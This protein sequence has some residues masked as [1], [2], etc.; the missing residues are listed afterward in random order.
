MTLS[1]SDL[2]LRF[3]QVLR[4]KPLPITDNDP[5]RK[6]AAVL[7]PFVKS[8]GEWH[9]LFTKRTNGVGRHR[10]E[11]SFPGGAF[12]ESDGDLIDTAMRETCEEIG[13]P[14]SR[15]QILGVLDPIPTVS[16]YCVL[17]VVSIIDWPQPLKLNEEEVENILIIPVNWLKAK[18]NWYQDDFYYEPGKFKAVIHYKDYQGEHLWGI[19]ALLAQMVTNYL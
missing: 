16:N 14:R 18:E 15:I 4:E 12:D 7:I 5:N 6:P 13:I 2:E 10:G 11:I 1:G 3:K 17:P 9:L 19:T 8:G